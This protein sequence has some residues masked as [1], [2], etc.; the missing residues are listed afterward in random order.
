MVVPSSSTT[1][2]VNMEYIV[3]P[4]VF[5]CG[6]SLPNAGVC[7]CRDSNGLLFYPLVSPVAM[8]AL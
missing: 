8:I 7:V 4:L 1:P 3:P 5:T 6:Q 2:T